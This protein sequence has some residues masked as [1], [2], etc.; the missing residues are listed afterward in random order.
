M[1]LPS[2]ASQKLSL[3]ERRGR[4]GSSEG[5]PTTVPCRDAMISVQTNGRP[6]RMISAIQPFLLL[7]RPRTT[8]PWRSRTAAWLGHQEPGL[9]NWTVRCLCLLP[10]LVYKVFDGDVAT[11]RRACW[12]TFPG[13]TLLGMALRSHREP[14]SAVSVSRFQGG[15]CTPGK[16]NPTPPG[17]SCQ[18]RPSYLKLPYWLRLSLWIAILTSTLLLKGTF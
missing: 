7:P 18:G 5:S 13:G 17:R 6:R 2:P 12:K 14:R 15:P 9:W 8:T 16:L 4:E 3:E 10:P 11:L 1:C